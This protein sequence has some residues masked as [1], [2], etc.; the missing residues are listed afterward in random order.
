MKHVESA[1][2][3]VVDV[4]E[5][6][7]IPY[8]LIGGFALTFWGVPRATVDVDLN[9]WVEPEKEG[10]VIAELLARFRPLRPSPEEFVRR[11]HVLPVAVGEGTRVDIVLARLPYEREMIRRAITANLRGR[12]VQV[13]ALEDLVYMK[14]ISERFRDQD[15]VTNLLRQNRKRIDRASLEPRVRE[16]AEQLAMPEILTLLQHELSRP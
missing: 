16:A 15:D 13:V 12:P 2:L 11:H 14:I 6:L 10:E 7:G 3:E 8:M 5:P 1:F 9:I 4:L